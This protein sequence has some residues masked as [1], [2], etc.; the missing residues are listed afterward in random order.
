MAKI[1]PLLGL[2]GG[3]RGGDDGG[4]ERPAVSGAAPP[5]EDAKTVG[6]YFE[7]FG[8]VTDG[9]LHVDVELPPYS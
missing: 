4:E 9:F 2:R 3:G 5:L 6:D 7:E 1:N 8:D